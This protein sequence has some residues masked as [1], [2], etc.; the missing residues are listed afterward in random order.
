MLHSKVYYMELPGDWACA[1]VGSHN[2]T[3]FAMNGLNGEASILLEGPTNSVEFESIR[4]HIKTA[5]DQAVI[6][7][8]RMKEAYSWWTR[9]FLDG[10]KA[11]MEMPPD[12]TI[13]RTILIFASSVDKER[14]VKGQHLYFELTNGV[15]IDSLKTEAHLFL[16]DSLPND[17]H[18]ALQM[19]PT[20]QASYTCQVLGVENQQGNLELKAHW[21][22][23]TG[24]LPKLGR[25]LS[26]V[27]RPITSVTKQQIR[28]EITTT[29]VKSYDYDFE[30]EKV[31]WWPIFADEGELPVAEPQSP[32]SARNSR[33]ESN[34]NK[35]KDAAAL[36]LVKPDSGCFILV[37]L[38][39][40]MR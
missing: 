30:S 39:R 26:G 23:E 25:I 5:A 16:F 3:A 1:F 40:R 6:Y 37:S 14:P 10:L 2:L 38:R 29:S 11:K 8:P 27:L 24:P 13:I 7:S 18:M 19:I 35:E 28:A 21:Q 34:V 9:E 17:A 12:W 31:G 20:V 22:I 32:V 4:L 33:S 36:Q 15:A